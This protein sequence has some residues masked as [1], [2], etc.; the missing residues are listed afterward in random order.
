MQTE[1]VWGQHLI[2]D[3]GGCNENIARKESIRA[4]VAEL[5]DAI[6]E[7]TE[8]GSS[9]RANGLRI[10]DTVMESTTKLIAN[11]EAWDD[12]W[13]RERIENIALLLQGALAAD[14]SVLVKMNVKE[15]NLDAVSA[16]L[17]ALH[18]PTVN[19]L[20]SEGW[21]SVESVVEERVV[22]DIIPKLKAAGAEGIIEIGLNKIV[23]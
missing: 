3:I 22:R 14:F 13:K 2:L 4:F 1:N 21:C 15:E 12:A 11:R 20:S 5:V 9:L 19:R 10:V 18:A 17:P 23:S 16:I 6:V 7:I 8:T